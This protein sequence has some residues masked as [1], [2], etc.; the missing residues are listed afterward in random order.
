MFQIVRRWFGF[1][2]ILRPLRPRRRRPNR[3]LTLARQLEQAQFERL[4]SREMLYGYVRAQNE[5]PYTAL[6]TQTYSVAAPGVL[7][8][9]DFRNNGVGHDHLGLRQHRH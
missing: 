4:E 7:S 3:R 5:G 6:N 9:P 2:M 1:E 8:A